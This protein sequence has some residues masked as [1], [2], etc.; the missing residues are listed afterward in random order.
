MVVIFRLTGLDGEAT[1]DRIESLPDD[2]DELD[3]DLEKKY[4]LAQVLSKKFTG[5]DGEE[6]SG[7]G[8][9]LD[10]VEK[11]EKDMPSKDRY[12]SESLLKMLELC[13][14]IKVNR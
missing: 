13:C 5:F 12:Y 6:S 8:I 14:R 9:L 10:R 7:I 2:S 11:L 1:E 4:E 3:G